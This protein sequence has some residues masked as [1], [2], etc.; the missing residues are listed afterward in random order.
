MWAVNDMGKRRQEGKV[1]LV[2]GVSSGLGLEFCLDLA[3]ASCKIIAAARL[4]DQLQSFCHQINHLAKS[5]FSC[6]ISSSSSSSVSEQTRSPR[7]V[8][9]ELDVCA[10]GPIIE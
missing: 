5:H 3:K 9:V 6:S 7:A 4:I 1:V 8:A 2:T 10:N